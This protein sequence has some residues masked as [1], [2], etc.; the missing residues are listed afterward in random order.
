LDLQS[1][2]TQSQVLEFY[3]FLLQ[4]PKKTWGF[5]SGFERFRPV[6]LTPDPDP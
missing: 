6:P 1:S 3:A 2:E 4:P 5:F